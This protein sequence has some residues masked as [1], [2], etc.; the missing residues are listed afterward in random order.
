M[1]QP[2]PHQQFDD[3]NLPTEELIAKRQKEYGG[4][5]K[6]SK[7]TQELMRTWKAA[8]EEA[9][10]FFNDAQEEGMHMIFH[11]ISRF[12]FGIRETRRRHTADICGYAQLVH[13]ATE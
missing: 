13:E 7:L 8:C 6:N 9:G 3:N 1:T 2:Q 4:F 5:D 12:T 10:V 11:K